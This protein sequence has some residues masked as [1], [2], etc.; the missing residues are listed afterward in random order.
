MNRVDFIYK[1]VSNL[2]VE[3]L[4][5]IYIEKEE[6]KIKAFHPVDEKIIKYYKIVK[7]LYI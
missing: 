1:I 6:G 7:E 5:M 4:S 3:N 2:L